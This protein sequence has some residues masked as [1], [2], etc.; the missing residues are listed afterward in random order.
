M[1][2]SIVSG[3]V[4]ALLERIRVDASAAVPDDS[5]S[6]SSDVD[7]LRCCRIMGVPVSADSLL[8]S[9]TR[10][11]ADAGYRLVAVRCACSSHEHSV[12]IGSDM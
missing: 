9:A 10:T 11:S 8:E 4:F 7:C 5:A 2:D 3:P 6:C 12:P 1:G